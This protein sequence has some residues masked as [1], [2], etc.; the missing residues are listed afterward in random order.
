MATPSS[1]STTRAGTRKAHQKKGI[2]PG[3][4]ISHVVDPS[5]IPMKLPQIW[6]EEEVK[7]E[8][9]QAKLNYEDPEGL[10][11]LPEPLQ[12]Q[13]AEWK[14]PTELID[15]I[16]NATMIFEK[17]EEKAA[18]PK[19]AAKKDRRKTPETDAPIAPSIVEAA[20]KPTN[21]LAVALVSDSAFAPI[22]ST[23]V[24]LD[25]FKEVIFNI[26]GGFQQPWDLIY[27]KG[28]DG[29]P[30]INPAGKYIVKLYA[31]GAWRRITMDDRIPMSFEGNVLLPCSDHKSEIWPMILTKAILK[32]ANSFSIG[33]TTSEPTLIPWICGLM[34]KKISFPDNGEKELP[35]EI[36][37]LSSVS[38]LQAPQFIQNGTYTDPIDNLPITIH[39]GD[40]YA[41][42]GF[43]RDEV[44][45]RS[46]VK[47]RGAHAKGVTI[48]KYLVDE[49][50]PQSMTS[51]AGPGGQQ[52]VPLNS[53]PPSTSM[54][55]SSDDIDKGPLE[56]DTSNFS[57]F[58]MN[59]ADFLSIFTSVTTYVHPETH[60]ELVSDF[61]DDTTKIY[62]PKQPSILHTKFEEPTI[63]TFLVTPAIEKYGTSVLSS[64]F[65]LEEYD[66]MAVNKLIVQRTQVTR[67][68]YIDVLIPAGPHTYQIITESQRGC[69]YRVFC[70]K[71]FHL[72][73]ANKILSDQLGLSAH[74]INEEYPIL[75]EGTWNV[76]LRTCVRVRE[77]ALF[78]AQLIVVEDL[79]IPYVRL[80][81]VDNDTLEETPCF[82]TRLPSMYL[83]PNQ[84]GYT[85]LIDAKPPH[86][87]PSGK[88]KVRFLCDVKNNLV[89]DVIPSKTVVDLDGQAPL[90]K[91]KEF[92]RQSVKVKD[93]STVT[94]QLNATRLT[95]NMAPLIQLRVYEKGQEIRFQEARGSS[96][97]FQVVLLP[98][99]SKAGDDRQ[100][101]IE[102]KYVVEYPDVDPFL[103][104]PTLASVASAFTPTAPTVPTNSAPVP[105]GKDSKPEAAAASRAINGKSPL[106]SAAVSRSRPATPNSRRTGPSHLQ[107]DDPGY[108]WHL[109]IVSNAPLELKKDTEREDRMAAIKDAWDKGGKLGRAAKGRAIR[110]QFLIKSQQTMETGNL[111]VVSP[112][113]E[114]IV[115]VAGDEG[116]ITLSTQEYTAKKDAIKLA[117][118]GVVQLKESLTQSREK[119]RK[120]RTDLMASLESELTEWRSNLRAQRQIDTDI[121]EQYRQKC[122]ADREKE[123]EARLA[124]EVVE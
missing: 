14:R 31:F 96:T 62:R 19:D 5:L 69:G 55:I 93:R 34:P 36:H 64:T 9:W 18:N 54:K 120:E 114:P 21:S 75:H 28:K 29:K 104:H 4:G 48:Q 68:K 58:H 109:R 98:P 77:R 79:L 76:M 60:T 84:S 116:G 52:I 11:T 67:A 10:V 65:L 122:I 6:D 78:S 106:P 110:E 59:Q 70:S 46:Y 38:I 49:S 57:F 88:Y 89:V 13:I 43:R 108:E 117:S 82:L 121:R 56:T 115:R 118:D 12:G 80:T 35:E 92:F 95:T 32:L 41:F 2:E 94:M 7:A 53:I 87:F 105:P 113:Q 33:I 102:G 112:P 123:M 66:W 72:G 111:D 107:I 83:E 99:E 47:L 90:N 74:E 45:N 50:R 25:S 16:G 51:P 71:P 63:M 15:R 8:K 101:I 22:T 3:V 119:E 42:C 81:F 40:V 20:W 100:Y 86:T 17:K 73:E 124:A 1:R 30:T 85:I 37:Q 97:V 24:A 23:L 39:P 26:V 103:I 91:Y 44:R 61:W 27:P